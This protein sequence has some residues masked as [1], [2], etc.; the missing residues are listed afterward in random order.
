MAKER[1]QPEK[2]HG[3]DAGW[4]PQW[5]QMELLRP[6]PEPPFQSPSELKMLWGEPWG[7]ADDVGP[8]KVVLM[9]RPG[10]EF[11]GLADPSCWRPELDMYFEPKRGVYW[12]GAT[13]P[14][15]TLVAAQHQGLADALDAEGVRVVFAEQVPANLRS[16]VFVRD[17]LVTIRGGAII[18]RMAA[19]SRRGEEASITKAVAAQGMPILHT[20]SGTGLMEGGTF[21]KLRPD[22]AVAGTGLRC[23][24]EAARQLQ[25]VLRPFG[26]ELIVV[27]LPGFLIHI[28][29]A[30]AMVDVDKALVHASALPWWFLERMRELHI[31][32]LWCHPDSE[33][34]AAVNC[35]AVRPG[36]VIMAKG[37]PRTAEMLER[38][39]VEV[40]TVDY[41][42]IMKNDGGVHCSTMELL[43]EDAS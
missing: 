31:E 25:D 4:L 6:E 27:P 22:V 1:A 9:R 14:D 11:E 19:R 26:I 30:L 12:H 13:P 8:L 40:I 36:R 39:G 20:I 42:E 3:L 38:R 5:G 32:L 43:R 7:A 16:A 34:A 41:D 18:C 15:M 24:A 17:P 29:G 28:D 10:R 23:N 37:A 35:L 33:E 21:V 2:G